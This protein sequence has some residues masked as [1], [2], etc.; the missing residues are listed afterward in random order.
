MKCCDTCFEIQ[1]FA[2]F[3]KR[4]PAMRSFDGRSNKCRSCYK[5]DPL[6]AEARR[7]ND[8]AF[9]KR[10]Y[11]DKKRHEEYKKR[12]REKR[13][14]MGDTYKAMKKK[15]GKAYYAKLKKDPV[16][17][18]ERMEKNKKYVLKKP[19]KVKK[20]EWEKAYIN[21]LKKD[22]RYA[23]FLATRS[24]KHYLREYGELGL[25]IRNLTKE[26]KLRRENE[27]TT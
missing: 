20:R 19:T 22:G 14:S 13:I 18:N 23:E 15:W 11:N 4:T 24:K 3:Y 12:K 5:K 10:L 26:I 16:R 27:R 1:E 8:H 6:R 7:K 9:K 25:L 17:Y 2:M 21:K